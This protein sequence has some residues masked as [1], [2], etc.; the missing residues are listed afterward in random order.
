MTISTNKIQLTIFTMVL[1]FD[2]NITKDP[3]VIAYL[4]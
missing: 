1:K 4:P 2:F 3:D